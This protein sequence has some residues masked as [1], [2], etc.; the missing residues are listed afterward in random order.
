[1]PA[2]QLESGVMLLVIWLAMKRS[3]IEGYLA[4]GIF[5]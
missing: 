4:F 5:L 3:V 1:M 2:L